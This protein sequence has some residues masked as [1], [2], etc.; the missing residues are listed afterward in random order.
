ML[1]Q[2]LLSLNMP[3]LCKQCRSRSVGFWRS[4]LIWICSLHCLLLSVWICIN[5]LDQVI[6]L[7][8]SNRNGL[9][10]HLNLFSMTRVHYNCSR[11]YF[12]FDFLDKIGLVLADDSQEMPSLIFLK[13]NKKKKTHKITFLMSLATILFRI[14]KK[15]NILWNWFLH[16]PS[17]IIVHKLLQTRTCLLNIWHHSKMEL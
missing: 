3:C 14:F 8:D 4:Q 6:W 15:V 10:W 1:T 5:N 7:A 12:D 16:L 17:L 2:V 13:K 11:W 9:A